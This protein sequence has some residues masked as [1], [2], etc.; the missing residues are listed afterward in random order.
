MAD[1]GSGLCEQH[2]DTT[3]CISPLDP[4]TGYSGYIVPLEVRIALSHVLANDPRPH[5]LHQSNFAEAGIAYP[6]LSG[7]LSAYRSVFA[8]NAP[9]VS[10]RLRDAATAL[11]QSA[12]WS[13]AADGVVAYVLNNAVWVSAPSGSATV[14]I[15]APAGT[16]FG[17]AYGGEVS[18]YRAVTA[19]PWKL[20]LPPGTY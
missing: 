2:P 5:Y 10:L 12:A 3:T 7:V 9:V 16:G 14:P 1:G 20:S 8:D 11:Q 17:K 13:A 18:G 15:T 6:V 19:T 4:A